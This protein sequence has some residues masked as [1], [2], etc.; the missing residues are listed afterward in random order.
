MM[1]RMIALLLTVSGLL[2]LTCCGAQ[3]EAPDVEPKIEEMKAICE[4]SVMEC[5]YHNVAKRTEKDAGGILWWQKD[6]RFWIEYGGVVKLG[7]DASLVTMEI[8]N[9]QV[10]I[11]MPEA[12]VLDC[13]VDENELSE[14]SYIVDKHSAKVTGED[15]IKAFEKA[16]QQLREKASNDMTLLSGAQERAKSL[17]EDYV[18][19][20]GAVTGKSYTIEWVYVDEEG[21]PLKAQPETSEPTAQNTEVSPESTQA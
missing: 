10:R 4:L 9:E 8:Q 7:I 17:L 5:Y 21:T 14:D 19:N 12:K 15:E 3:K 20:I 2:L 18:N 16:Q 13:S 6:K 1:K 11:T